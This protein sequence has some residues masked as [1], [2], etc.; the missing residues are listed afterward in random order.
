M[1][2]PKY[3]E[4]LK[5]I[6]E[7]LADEQIWRSS[8]ITQPLGENLEL[9]PEAMMQMYDSGNPPPIFAD[10][11]TWAISQLYRAGLLDRPRRAH[12]QI[13]ALGKQSLSKTP[14]ELHQYTKTLAAQQVN[15]ETEPALSHGDKTPQEQLDEVYSAIRQDTYREILDTILQKTP[16]AFEHLVVQLLQRIGYGSEVE[17]SALITQ[18]SRDGGIDAVIREDALG[19]ERICIQAKRYNPN[20]SVPIKEIRDFVGALS[21]AN[22][23]KGVFITTARFSDDTKKYAQTL[24]NLRIVLIDGIKLAEYIY[25]YNLGM[26]TEQTFSIKKLDSDFWENLPNDMSQKH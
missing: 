21:G 14:D 15:D 23:S 24:S 7:L 6:L 13:N 26:Q 8:D 3:Q 1:Y 16:T 25:D 10:R 18:A 22:A 9:M 20:S 11:V 2:I 4:L 5:P 12:Y 19:L 17:N